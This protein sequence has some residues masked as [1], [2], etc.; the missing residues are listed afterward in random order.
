MSTPT[1]TAR[2]KVILDELG[3]NTYS[4]RDT[5]SSVTPKLSINSLEQVNTSA[6]NGDSEIMTS[7]APSTVQQLPITERRA[8]IMSRSWAELAQLV[9]QCTACK[10]CESRTQTVFGVGDV[11]PQWVI[12]GEAPGANEDAQ[13]EPFVGQSG[14]LLD[15]MLASIGL[16]RGKGVYIL[17]TIKC[18][19]PDNRNPEPDEM[20]QC[21]PFLKRQLELLNPRIILCVGKFAITSLL[22]TKESV[23]SLRGRV[24]QYA[25][26]PTIVTYHPAYLLRNLVAKGD[27]WADLCFARS[28]AERSAHEL[29]HREACG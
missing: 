23:G 15:N 11:K 13:G 27:A 25:G 18:R 1:K 8:H 9:P 28:I 3:I 29:Q 10:L 19:P 12:I 5:A 24:H 26:I 4:L 7:V 16:A 20:A 2:R 17:N 21:E 14:K 22:N 6:S